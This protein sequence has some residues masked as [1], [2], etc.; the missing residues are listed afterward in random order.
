MRS[1]EKDGIVPTK[2]KEKGK[3]LYGISNWKNIHIITEAK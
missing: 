1:F 3:V 2:V